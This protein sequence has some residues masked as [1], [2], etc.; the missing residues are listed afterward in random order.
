MQNETFRNYIVEK[1]SNSGI[2][3]EELLNNSSA[4]ASHKNQLDRNLDSLK[5]SATFFISMAYLTSILTVSTVV[6]KMFNLY[7]WPNWN[8]SYLLVLWTISSIWTCMNLKT[9]IAKTKEQI[10]LLDILKKL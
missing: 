9:R 6:V 2:K 5:S 1:L 8:H 10:L 3:N 7:S 4:L